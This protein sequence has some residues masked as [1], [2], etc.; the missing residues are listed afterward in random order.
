MINEI[1]PRVHN[2]GHHTL[3]SSTISQFELH[4][5][6]ILGMDLG[7]TS[8]N[9]ATVMYNILGPVTF[10]GEYN[11]LHRHE[12]NVFL[13]MYGKLESKPQ[14][15]IGHVNI[16]DNKNVGIEGLLEQVEDLKKNLVIEPTFSSAEDS[17]KKRTQQT[18]GGWLVR[19][20]KVTSEISCFS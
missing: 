1:A 19:L 18:L 6:A 12:D 4:L 9:S 11:I 5:R 13:K 10:K 20:P 8:I 16:V 15:K 2:S 3:Q 17:K 14:S 7:D